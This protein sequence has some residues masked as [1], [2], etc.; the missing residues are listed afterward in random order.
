MDNTLQVIDP[1]QAPGGKIS[2]NPQSVF[3]IDEYNALMTGN[4]HGRFRENTHRGHNFGVCTIAIGGQAIS[5]GYATTYTGLYLYNPAYSG[6][7]AS[8]NCITTALL[9]AEVAPAPLLIGRVEGAGTV[10]ET[11]S[12]T[13][14]SCSFGPAAQPA[15]AMHTGYA[16]TLTTLSAKWPLNGLGK[17]A[18]RAKDQS[19]PI[20]ID[21]GFEVLPGQ[22]IALVAVTAVTGFWGF[23]WDEIPQ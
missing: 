9:V 10:A 17:T 23:Y 18:D 5:V 7:V 14:F 4:L 1:A 8:L 21:G 6:Y 3:R 11:S 2:P 22:C 12:L 16:A 19:G 15:S 13:P 20:W